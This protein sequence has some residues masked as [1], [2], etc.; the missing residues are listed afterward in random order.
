MLAS[1][2]TRFLDKPRSRI[3]IIT[4]LCTRGNAKEIIDSHDSLDS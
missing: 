4:I 3:H 2:R 1:I